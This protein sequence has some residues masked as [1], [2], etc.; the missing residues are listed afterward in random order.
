LE[1]A[2]WDWQLINGYVTKFLFQRALSFFKACK[3]HAHGSLGRRREEG[4]RE[5]IGEVV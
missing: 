5:L 1:I 4:E 3:E 2:F